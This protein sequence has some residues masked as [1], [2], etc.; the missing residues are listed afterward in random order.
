MDAVV[1]EPV[2]RAR[3]LTKTDRSGEVEVRALCEVD[4]DIARGLLDL[5]TVPAPVLI[6]H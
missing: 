6:S 4:L 2:F 3:G 5:M 1:V